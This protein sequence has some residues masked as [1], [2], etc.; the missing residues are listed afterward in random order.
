MQ[1]IPIL[2]VP[3]DKY[4]PLKALIGRPW[5]YGEL[6]E[7]YRLRAEGNAYWEIAMQLKRIT[8]HVKAAIG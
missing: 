2:G 8:N 7:A 6:R 4:Q 3:K 5:T 1:D